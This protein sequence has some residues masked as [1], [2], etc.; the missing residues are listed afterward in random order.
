MTEL[1]GL[2]GDYGLFDTRRSNLFN[3]FNVVSV[4]FSPCYS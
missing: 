3:I 2:H 4:C 1:V